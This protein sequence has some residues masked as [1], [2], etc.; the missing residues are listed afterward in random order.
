VHET[1]A[2]G[3]L[4]ELD[5]ADDLVADA[6]DLDAPNEAGLRLLMMGLNGR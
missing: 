4:G 1:R 3:R 5:L 2:L 6:P